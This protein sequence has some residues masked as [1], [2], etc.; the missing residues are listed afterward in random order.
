MIR[1]VGPGFVAGITPGSKKDT[2]PI[3]QWM[4]KRGMSKQ[5]IIA[6]CRRVGWKHSVLD[7]SGKKNPNAVLTPA[8]VREIRRL[9]DLGFGYQWLANWLGVTK[10]CVQKVCNGTTWSK[11]IN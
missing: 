8:L 10:S 6:H 11:N 5:Q 1:V 2:A 9:N 7:R 4:I 3:L